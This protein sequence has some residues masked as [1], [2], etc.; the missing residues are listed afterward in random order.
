M[1]PATTGRDAFNLLQRERLGVER[2]ALLGQPLLLR[3]GGGQSLLRSRYGC[4]AV[5]PAGL[6]FGA[7]GDRVVRVDE[8]LANLG[9]G[10]RLLDGGHL[11][12]AAP[13]ELPPLTGLGSEFE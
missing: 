9:L 5:V 1:A 7:E 8:R 12:V 10:L 6:C 11:G 13:A 4:L 2:L 3:L